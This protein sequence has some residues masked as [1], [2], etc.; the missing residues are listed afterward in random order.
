MEK[1]T[2]SIDDVTI[3]IPND[4]TDLDGTMIAIQLALE[5]KG[6]HRNT[7]DEW[8]IDRAFNLENDKQ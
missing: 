1:T 4:G 6:W 7:I 2:I 3:T 8:I 5:L